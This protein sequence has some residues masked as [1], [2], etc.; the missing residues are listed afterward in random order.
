MLKIKLQTKNNFEYW[1]CIEK[2]NKLTKLKAKE[3]LNTSL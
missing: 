3:I 2:K 1:I